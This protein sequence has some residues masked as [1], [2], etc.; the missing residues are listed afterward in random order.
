MNHNHVKMLRAPGADGIQKEWVPKV[1]DVYYDE[2]EW[3]VCVS[4]IGVRYLIDYGADILWLPRIEDYMGMCRNKDPH[5]LS[6]DIA[7]FAEA[8]K[9][10][11]MSY[12]TWSEFM[13]AFVQHECKGL[14]WDGNIWR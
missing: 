11:C 10:R 6:Y 7:Y 1:G 2:G 8:E 12:E 13:L 14:S 5:T 9:V 3:T 4:P